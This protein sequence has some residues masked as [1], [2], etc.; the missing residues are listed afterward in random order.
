MYSPE[1]RNASRAAS[2]SANF[3]EGLVITLFEVTDK[4]FHMRLIAPKR[5]AE[6]NLLDPLYCGVHLCKEDFE[7]NN[8]ALQDRGRLLSAYTSQDGTKFWIIT[9]ADRSATT[10][11]LP[12]EY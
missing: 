9:E 7:S 1:A 10:F 11:L 6:S 2:F 3:A 5:M 12:S 4:S 8:Q